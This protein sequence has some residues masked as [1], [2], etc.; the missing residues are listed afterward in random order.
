MMIKSFDSEPSNI[1]NIKSSK[2][3]ILY[4]LLNL[5][6]VIRNGELD[7]VYYKGIWGILDV[8]FH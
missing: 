2:V 7:Q 5:L 4:D 3:F 8:L 1:V 6:K